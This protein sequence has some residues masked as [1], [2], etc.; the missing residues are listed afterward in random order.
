MVIIALRS[1]ERTLP[2][3][4]GAD[5]AERIVSEAVKFLSRHILNVDD[6]FSQMIG[7]YALKVAVDAT[8]QH[9]ISQ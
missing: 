2:S 4:V 8:S 1:T 3:G 5:K 7:T 9:K 6:L